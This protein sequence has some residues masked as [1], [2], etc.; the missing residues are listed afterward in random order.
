[1]KILLNKKFNLDIQIINDG[2]EILNT[3]GGILNMMNSSNESDFLTL[4]P[5]TVWDKNYVR[6]SKYGKILFF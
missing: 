1:M 5:D 3:G 6:N 4:N 2:K